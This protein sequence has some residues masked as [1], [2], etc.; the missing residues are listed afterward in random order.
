MHEPLLRSFASTAELVAT[1]VREEREAAAAMQPWQRA[2]APGNRIAYAYAWEGGQ[3]LTIYFEVL[4][5]E[6]PRLKAS[7]NVGTRLFDRLPGGRARF[8]VAL[9]CPDHADAG[10]VGSGALPGMA[11][12]RLHAIR[13]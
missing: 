8:D 4:P 3:E 7:R 6:G 2:L 11:A 10:G 1:L 5:A 12:D 13:L 9:Q